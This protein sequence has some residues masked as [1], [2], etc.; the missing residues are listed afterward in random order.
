M[1]KFSAIIFALVVLTV[2]SLGLCARENT[3]V[4]APYFNVKPLIDG[5]VST[6]E[7]GQPTGSAIIYT[8]RS[9]YKYDDE[10]NVL[11]SDTC[12]GFVHRAM[13]VNDCSFDFWLRWDE[14]FFYIA[15]VSKDEYG[16]AANYN[17]DSDPQ[18]CYSY[19][20]DGDALQ[21]GIDPAGANSKGNTAQPFDEFAV[22]TF[23]YGWLDEALT[24]TALRN[25]ANMGAL[26]EGYKAN[27]TWN[28]G[29][30]PSFGGQPN[31][32][33]GYTTYELAVPYSLFAGNVEEGKTNGFGV[34]LARISATPKD[35]VDKDGNIIGCSEND[36]WLTWGDGLVGSLKDQLPQ[37]R[38]GTNSVI[39][40]DAPAV[41]A[42][43]VAAPEAVTEPAAA[44]G[45]EEETAAA[46]EPAE[47]DGSA[48]KAAEE[49]AEKS[50]EKSAEE[51]AEVSGDVTE[52]AA[53]AEEPADMNET[54]ENAEN[55]ENAEKTA[56]TT[57]ADNTAEN[58]AKKAELAAK[59]A[60]EEAA[61][62]SGG[63]SKDLLIDI[64]AAVVVVLAVAAAIFVYVR[65]RR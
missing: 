16:L 19:L 49:A 59:L 12:F 30:W 53:D 43:S 52:E 14:Q 29:V 63:I 27:I 44:E 45:P 47:A 38:C 31:S 37:Y 40:T 39:L 35:A 28:P 62:K 17:P 60:A 56:E 11:V 20:W 65:K 32:D 58:E 34:T 41:G 1:K 9:D 36:V 15:V 64:I 5:V 10:D 25:D 13:Y 7:W 54:G 50:A 23:V 55:A 24:K 4:E 26:C 8:G 48:E 61:Q 57:A 51:T 42:G 33:P 3:T 22:N 21:F 46:G 18:W 6:A 2:L